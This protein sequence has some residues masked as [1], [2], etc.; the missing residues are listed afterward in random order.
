[1]NKFIYINIDGF[2][3]SYY[4]RLRKEG[5]S[6]VFD[7]LAKDGI[8]FE[9]L[10]SGLVSITNPMQSAILCGAY[11]EKT[12]NF[13]Q[14]YDKNL[15]EVIKHK[16]T[17]DAENVADVFLKNGKNIASIHQFM[18]ENNPCVFGDKNKAYFSCENQPSKFKDR[19]KLLKSMVKGEVI[20]TGDVEVVYDELPD[21]LAMYIDDIDSLGH[22]NAYGKIPPR[23]IFEER[24]NDIIN[25]LVEIQNELSSF[26]DVCKD[27]GIYEDLTI[28]ITTDH[29]MTPFFGK[30][31]LSETIEN[32]NAKG[33]ITSTTENV[34]EN[35]QIV[36]LPYTI[37][38][39]LYFVK[40]LNEKQVETIKEVLYYNKNIDRIFDKSEMVRDF[41][42]DDRCADLIISP[43]YGHHFYKKDVQAGTFSASH[44]SFDETSQHIFGMI[45]GSGIRKDEIYNEKVNVIS[46]IP[47]IL[48]N[49]FSYKLKDSTAKII[50]LN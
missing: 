19:F 29:G 18:L 5:K 39:S 4:Q 30:S 50:K 25:C 3:Y 10:S 15:C 6:T 48:K 44:D 35:T 28:L 1:M 2:S 33:I 14:H 46:L 37:E 41:G 7:E 31:M 17:F 9:N 42:M 34:N 27:K 8:F 36:A 45:F 13:Y 47:S 21:F 20:K 49:N 16:R 38:L 23:C 11:S 22:N 12:H 32:L 43:K 40:Y 24:Q 26:I